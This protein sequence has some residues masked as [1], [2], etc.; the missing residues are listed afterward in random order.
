M[1]TSKALKLGNKCRGNG[2][3]LQ[4]TTEEMGLKSQTESVNS[5][6][7]DHVLTKADNRSGH[8]EISHKKKKKNL[9]S[10]E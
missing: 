2:W 9:S 3:E 8:L 1:S 7:P 6:G 10:A 5:W 4:D